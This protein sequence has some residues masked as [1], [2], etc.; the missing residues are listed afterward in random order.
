MHRDPALDA[1]LRRGASARLY[2]DR[3]AIF[4]CDRA[5]Q[6]NL[7]LVARL[8]PKLKTRDQHRSDDVT[9]QQGEV[10]A[11]A[12]A[13]AGCE[14]KRAVIFA[15]C[16]GKERETLPILKRALEARGVSVK[17]EFVFDKTGLGDPGRI[18]AMIS[19]IKNAGGMP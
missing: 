18:N 16:G 15:T 8:E 3:H 14:G 1:L 2:D 7:R 10:V 9:L 13:L 5:L 4:A 6:G 17:G 12:D 11:Q 19:R